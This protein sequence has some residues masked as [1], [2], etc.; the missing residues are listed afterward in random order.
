MFLFTDSNPLIHHIPAPPSATFHGGNAHILLPEFPDHHRQVS[1]YET[2][3]IIKNNV[4]TRGA[5]KGGGRLKPLRTHPMVF[6]SRT[7]R[8]KKV[9]IKNDR[10]TK[11]MT[12]QGLR[13]RRVRLSISVAR[14]FFD[15]QDTLGFDKPSKT[16]NWLF[17]KSRLAIEEL[18]R[19]KD[20]NALEMGKRAKPYPFKDESGGVGIGI[21]ECSGGDNVARESRAKAR[22]RARA[23][24]I[25]KKM[26]SKEAII[27]SEEKKKMLPVPISAEPPAEVPK[28]PLIIKS[29]L[30]NKSEVVPS[31]KEESGV[32]SMWDI[33]QHLRMPINKDLGS[34]NN[35]N[36][37]NN[38]PGNWNYAGSTTSVLSSQGN[39]SI[40]M[41][42]PN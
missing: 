16:L 13:D 25:I 4:L 21:D 2:D 22:A 36:N 20:E 28:L 9:A 31:K 19:A 27:M 7:V 38:N 10:H 33:P 12:A 15:L 37:N 30:H 14:K 39:I 40:Y 11:I 5:N 3:I 42:S 32:G 18:V 24:T 41:L 29:L 34:L 35:N 17:A 6:P 26:C 1:S 8:K 23:R